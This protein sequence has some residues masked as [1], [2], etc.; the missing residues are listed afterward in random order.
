MPRLEF[1]TAFSLFLAPLPSETSQRRGKGKEDPF[2]GEGPPFPEFP[3]PLMNPLA[4]CPSPS[5]R[6]SDP[7]LWLFVRSLRLR[8]QRQGVLPL[9]G[10]LRKRSRRL[11]MIP[12]LLRKEE[13]RAG[14]A[15]GKGRGIHKGVGRATGF[16]RGPKDGRRGGRKGGVGENNSIL[17]MIFVV[18]FL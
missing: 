7:R 12:F 4:V 15:G 8:R 17:R 1:G 2:K 10:L 9:S 11:L 16:I 14:G 6:P 5:F 13:T 18:K 3:L